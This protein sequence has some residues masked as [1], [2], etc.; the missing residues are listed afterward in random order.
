MGKFVWIVK[1]CNG[2]VTFYQKN[3]IYLILL[4]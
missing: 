4:K 3:K 2:F 1:G